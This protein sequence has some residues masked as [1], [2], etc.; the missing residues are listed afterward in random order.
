MTEKLPNQM[1]WDI[2]PIS[3]EV[4]EWRFGW[5]VVYRS[6]M[7]DNVY[8]DIFKTWSRSK[9]RALHNMYKKLK[10]KNLI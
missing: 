3:L 5:K 2:L 8:V 6:Y 1:L 4:F 10:D 9:E 7:N